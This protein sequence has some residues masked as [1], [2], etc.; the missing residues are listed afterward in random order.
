MFL[1]NSKLADKIDAINK[2]QAVIEFDLQGTIMD[3][4]QNF[5]NAMG[6]S[7]SEIKGKHHSMFVEP[8]YKNSQ[9][10]KDFWAGFKTGKFQQAEYCR[11]A[12]GGREVWIQASY[13]PLI[14]KN[15][16][17]YGVI[18]FATDITAQKLQNADYQGQVEAIGKSNAVISFELD[19]TIIE[20]NSNF[21]GA[22]GYQQSEVQGRHH[23]IF[24]DPKEKNTPQYREFWAK[25]ARGEYQAG[26]YKRI[27]KNGEE[28]WIQASYNPIFD[29]NGRPFKVVKYAVDITDQMNDRM[30]RQDLQHQIDID[31]SQI[32]ESVNK[33]MNQTEAATIS[34]ES[35]SENVQAV[36][37]GAEELAASIGEISAQVSHAREISASA[38]AQAEDTNNVIS[39]LAEASQ[40]I[41]EVVALINDIAEQTNLLALNATIEAARAGD[42]GK[43]FAVVANE[44]KSLASQTANAT[45]EIGTQ[46]SAVQESTRDSVAAIGSISSTIEQVN[47]ISTAIAA[48]IEEQTAVTQ[49]MSSNMHV[50]ADGVNTINNSMTEIAISTDFVSSAVLKVKEA[51]ESLN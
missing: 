28:I 49:N 45:N 3:A 10:Y 50:A 41:G 4:N 40:K 13:N 6:Y 20:A 48:A 7:L 34:S 29:M 23:S 2:S 39:G 42:A 8:D 35:A 9:D 15:G 27:A 24:M 16:R 14:G 17:P 37:T 31:L 18:K 19:G 26:E 22:V 21:L 32:T 1:Q 33:V 30:R 12:K 11:L 43:G 51:S 36:A 5:L 46:I 25:L 38:V 47:D 44:V